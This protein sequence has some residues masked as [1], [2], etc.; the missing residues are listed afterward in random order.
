M[1]VVAYI[2]FIFS[3]VTFGTKKNKTKR[4][5]RNEEINEDYH[6]DIEIRRAQVLKNLT[7]V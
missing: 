7:G 3:T 6:T 2:V 1:C 5:F 4:H